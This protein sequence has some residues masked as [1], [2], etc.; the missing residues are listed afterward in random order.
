MNPFCKK[1]H[2]MEGRDEDAGGDGYVR[3]YKSNTASHP[4]HMAVLKFQKGG[5][6]LN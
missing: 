3:N 4:D 1:E 2:T 6:K 5:M